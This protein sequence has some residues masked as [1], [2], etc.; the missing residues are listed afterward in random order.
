M[1]DYFILL[2]FVIIFALIFDYINGFHD[3]ANSIAT[4]VSTR[5]LRPFQAVI[6]AAILNLIGAFIGIEVAK[7]V[8][9]GIVD[10]VSVN[11]VTVLSALI[12]AIIWNLITWYYGIPSSSSHAIIGGLCGGAFGFGGF[13]MM[14]LKG[15]LNKVIIPMITSPIIGIFFGFFIMI[16]I[17][18]IVFY[19]KPGPINKIFSK[20]QILSAGF[21]ALS[22]GQ[23]DAQKTM[24]IITMAVISYS[25]FSVT[26][27][28]SPNNPEIK[29]I[30]SKFVNEGGFIKNE[31]GKYKAYKIIGKVENAKDKNLSSSYILE[32]VKEIDN[33]LAFEINKAINNHELEINS[34]TK[35]EFNVPKWVIFS[36]ALAMSLGTLAGGWRIIHTMGS[37][38]IKL[39]PINGF[40][41][42][43]TASLI[44]TT[45]SYFGI[46]LST[47]H[48]ISTSIMGVGV[49]KRFSA[50]KWRI[51]GN[52]IIAWILT[53]PVTFL[54]GAT[55]Y[56]IISNL[57]NFLK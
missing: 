28:N 39:Q 27:I 24:G 22:H 40:A 3:A 12:S 56:Y 8:G 38:M 49:A 26:N 20:L 52:I 47:T 17:Y 7:T 53:F 21:M 54:L 43:T 45:A 19:S 13:S 9:S 44:I 18:R 5:V 34:E 14:K 42:E 35:V 10:S 4:V 1:H 32:E 37:K 23:N 11:Q 2:I 48:V 41:A 50:V 25:V 31:N 33:K 30:V 51:V 57:L 36:C 6:M 55:F 15:V 46:P 16:I 29:N